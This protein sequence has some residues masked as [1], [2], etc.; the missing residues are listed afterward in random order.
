MSLTDAK[1]PSQFKL[2]DSEGSP[3][4]LYGSHGN[5]TYSITLTLSRSDMGEIVADAPVGQYGGDVEWGVETTKIE[6]I[7]R[8]Q[9]VTLSLVV[10]SPP[11]PWYEAMGLRMKEA[12]ED[13]GWFQQ[14]VADLMAVTQPSVSDW[15]TA[16]TKIDP[17]T[18]WRLSVVLHVNI[19][20]LYGL[21]DSK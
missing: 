8:G 4:L 6:V 13:R 17:K 3:Q 18:L 10:E 9:S 2:R 11:D 19:L 16:T 5:D 12:R 1:C 21:T 20:W 7:M 14:H 15:E